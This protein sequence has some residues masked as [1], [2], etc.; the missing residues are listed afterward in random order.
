MMRIF[1]PKHTGPGIWSMV[2]AGPNT[3]GAQ[4]F[5]WAAKPEWLDGEPVVFGKVKEDTDTVDRS[6]S[7]NGKTSQVTRIVSGQR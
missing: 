7:R 6:G 2:N 4:F 5:I 1:N 3:N